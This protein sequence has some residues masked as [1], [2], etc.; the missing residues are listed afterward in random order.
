MIAIEV[1]YFNSYETTLPGFYQSKVVLF[2]G[3]ITQKKAD[4]VAP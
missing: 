3:P 2:S 1:V 4:P